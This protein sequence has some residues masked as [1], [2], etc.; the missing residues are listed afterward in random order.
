MEQD[1]LIS[2]KISKSHAVVVTAALG[3]GIG[4]GAISYILEKAK[5]SRKMS[6]A[7]VGLPLIFESS[8][9]QAALDQLNNIVS[10]AD[11]TLIVDMNMIDLSGTNFFSTAIDETNRIMCD[12]IERLCRM[13]DGP[14]FSLFYE[15]AYTISYHDGLDPEKTA[16]IA[17]NSGF[18]DANPDHGKIIIN[19]DDKF[20]STDCNMILRSVCDRTGIMPDLVHDKEGTSGMMMFIPIAYRVL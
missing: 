13:I 7:V 5:R 16:I 15:K 11:R 1:G 2:E 20:S 10:N 18:V 8:R 17:L 19:V 3:G 9:R 12:A 14:F 6:V 4:S